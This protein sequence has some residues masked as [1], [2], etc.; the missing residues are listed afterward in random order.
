MHHKAHGGVDDILFSSPPRAQLLGGRAQQRRVQSG[1]QAAARG[2]VVLLQ[3]SLREQLR[4]VH[5]VG[6]PALGLDH[7]AQHL[8]ALAALQLL[9]KQRFGLFQIS[10]LPG[11]LQHARA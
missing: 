2:D 11:S 5:H 4:P 9:P 3:G 10:G 7:P 1:Q 8:R 6:I